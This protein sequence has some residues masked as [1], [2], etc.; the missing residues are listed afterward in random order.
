M[1]RLAEWRQALTDGKEDALAA[2][3]DDGL[4]AGE[5]WME[6]NIRAAGRRSATPADAH[7]RRHVPRSVRLPQVADPPPG[8]KRK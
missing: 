1:A 5:K 7:V 3:I 6:A 8:Q 4:V 2:A